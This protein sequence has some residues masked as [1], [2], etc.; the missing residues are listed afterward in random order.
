MQTHIRS[1]IIAR[2]GD[3]VRRGLSAQA[4]APL[5]YWIVR[6]SRTMTGELFEI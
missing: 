6:S 5:E 2:E 3:P 1:I 4:Q